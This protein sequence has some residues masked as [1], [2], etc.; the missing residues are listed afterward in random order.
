MRRVQL[1]EIDHQVV[2]FRIDR[3]LNAA[4]RVSAHSPLCIFLNSFADSAAGNCYGCNAKNQHNGKNGNIVSCAAADCFVQIGLRHQN[5]K[6]P[7]LS[8]VGR[9]SRIQDYFFYPS[10]VTPG[11]IFESVKVGFSFGNGKMLFRPKSREIMVSCHK[12]AFGMQKI[13]TVGRKHAENIGVV[14][15]AR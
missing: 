10:A 7:F 5:G 1:F 8:A 15:G 3:F 14:A 12:T 13:I 2:E 11:I 9:I 4:V 6:P